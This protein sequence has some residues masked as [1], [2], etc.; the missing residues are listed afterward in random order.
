MVS[1]GMGREKMEYRYIVWVGGI[2]NYFHYKEDAKDCA[3][4][5]REQGYEDI[6]IE[7]INHG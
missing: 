2:A 5:W 4:S 3:D 1:T 6:I 7:G